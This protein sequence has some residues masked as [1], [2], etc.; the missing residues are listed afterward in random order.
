LGPSLKSSLGKGET[1]P[2]RDI[3]GNVF[4]NSIN[5]QQNAFEDYDNNLI[6]EH[7]LDLNSAAQPAGLSYTF[8]G[9]LGY[10]CDERE[11]PLL[12]HIGGSYEFANESNATLDRWT[13]WAKTGVSF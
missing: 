8:Y 2:A 12:A 7:D 11:Y 6:K 13:L 4:L 5:I 3:T 9:S 10:R 1:N